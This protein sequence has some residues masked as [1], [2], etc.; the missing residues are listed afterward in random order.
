MKILKICR[1]NNMGDLGENIIW[2]NS[3][4]NESDRIPLD[5]RVYSALFGYL[6]ANT[7]EQKRRDA[8]EC[9]IFLCFALCSTCQ[10]F[11]HAKFIFECCVF[12]LYVSNYMHCFIDM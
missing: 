7:C 12:Q 10:D 1:Q 9:T 5:S 3:R 4:N 6:P 8:Y 2:S 11:G